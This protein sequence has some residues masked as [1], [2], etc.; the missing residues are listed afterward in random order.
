MREIYASLKEEKGRLNR[1]FNH[2][3]GAGRAGEIMRYTAALQLKETVKEC[4]FRYI[5]FHGIFHEDMAV[6]LTDTD[7]TVRYNFQYTDMLFDFLLECG[8]RPFLEL[9]FMPKCLAEGSQ[10]LFFWSANVTPPADYEK[11]KD[12]IACFIRHITERYGEEEIKQWFFEVWNEPNHPSFF[13]KSSDINAYLKLY[14]ETVAAIKSVNND[15]K[16]GGPASA[17][18]QW[19]DRLSK[20]CAENNVPLDFLSGHSY[21]TA[22]DFD[23]YGKKVLFLQNEFDSVINTVKYH[24]TIADSAS[25][26]MYITEWSSSYSSRDPI[27][28][29]YINAP[30]VLNVIR[31]L[32]G[33]ADSLSYWTYTDIFEEVTPPLT[34]FHGGFGL[35]NVQS[36]KKP[37]YYVYKFLNELGETELVSSD[38]CSYICRSADEVQVLFWN[39]V[40]QEQGKQ[41]D[42]KFYQ[43]LFPSNYREEVKVVIDGFA[44]GVYGIKAETIGYGKGDVYTVYTNGDYGSLASREKAEELKMASLPEMRSFESKV[45][46]NGRLV[47]TVRTNDNQID[48]IKIH[49]IR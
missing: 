4:G 3:V 20:Y 44:E 24:R 43:K 45:S 32:D 17:G 30:L 37:T 22:G 35:M 2:T 9:S 29:C 40:R 5:R 18:M 34:P 6:C 47:L 11:W 42:M 33:Y 31:N 23:E 27:H 36:F 7:G 48:F 15:Y 28:D 16:V 49:K 1:Y 19:L 13:S 38:K 12:F 41:N 8:I 26:P 25:L 14:S 46:E 21:C 10:T 39:Y